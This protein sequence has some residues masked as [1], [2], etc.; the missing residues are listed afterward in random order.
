MITP[1]GILML[2]WSPFPCRTTPPARTK[3]RTASWPLIPRILP[4]SN[5]LFS[6]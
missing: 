6:G 2:T 4:T 5:P 1:D 3:A